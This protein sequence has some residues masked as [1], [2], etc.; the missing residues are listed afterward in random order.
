LQ[1]KVQGEKISG[2]VQKTIGQVERVLE[3]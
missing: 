2:K 1:A 3:K